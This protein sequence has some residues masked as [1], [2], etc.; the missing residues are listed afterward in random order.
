MGEL[1][2]SNKLY[3]KVCKYLDDNTIVLKHLKINVD[4]IKLK[5][6]I[7]EHCLF[8]DKYIIDTTYYLSNAIKQNKKILLEGAQG[9]LLDI[10]HGTYPYVT[11]SNTLSGGMCV[12]SSIGIKNIKNIIGIVKAYNTRVG[13]GPFVSEDFGKDGEIMADVGCEVGTTT[14]RGRR[15]GWL[16]LVALKYACELNSVTELSL[17]KLDI[18][19]GFK[20]LKICTKYIKD[21]KLIDYMPSNLNGVTPYYE[22]I[23]GWK[24]TMGVQNFEALCDNSKAY[25]NL[26]EQYTNT[27]VSII[28]TSPKREDVILR[29]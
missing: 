29:T 16:D 23:N 21:G 18:L 27:K 10:D 6:E 1:K 24:K 17:M 20:T 22:E 13:N 5:Q 15:C 4:K 26:I 8:L 3:A 7:E 2:N 28:S 9:T 11:S 14:G 12:G 19:D 25:I